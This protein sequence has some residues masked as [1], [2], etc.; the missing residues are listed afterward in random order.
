M[1][2]IWDCLDKMGKEKEV[3]E[4][5]KKIGGSLLS[6]CCW[7]TPNSQLMSLTTQKQGKEKLANKHNRKK[8]FQSSLDVRFRRMMKT[9]IKQFSG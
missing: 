1:V 2:D 7:Q 9:D 8:H 6:V 4:K 3:V 5:I